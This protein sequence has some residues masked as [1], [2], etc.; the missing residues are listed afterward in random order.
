VGSVD[1]VVGGLV[2]T[3]RVETGVGEFGGR[4]LMLVCTSGRRPS[5]RGGGVGEAP[6]KTASRELIT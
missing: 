6:T 4:G 1:L 2:G 5:G 3:V